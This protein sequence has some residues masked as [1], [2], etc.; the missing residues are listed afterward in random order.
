MSSLGG[1]FLESLFTVAHRG[2]FEYGSCEPGSK[3]VSRGLYRDQLGPLSKC[4]LAS[5]VYIHMEYFDHGSCDLQPG[6]G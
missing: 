1:G 3:L 6:K 4:Y 5:C 2:S